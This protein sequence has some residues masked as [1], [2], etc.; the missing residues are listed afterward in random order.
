MNNSR[1]IGKLNKNILKKYKI[2]TDDIVLTFE[3]RKHIYIDHYNDFEEIMLNLDRVVL[4][5]DEILENIKNIDTIFMIGK[6]DR[7]SLNVVVKLNTS[8]NNEH[9]KNSVMTAWI[10]RDKNLRKLRERNMVI[11]KKE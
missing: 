10:I 8:V 9:P 7:N 5:P 11:Y 1:Y 3:R 6:L 2:I 4:T